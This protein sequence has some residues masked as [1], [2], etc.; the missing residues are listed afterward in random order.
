MGTEHSTESSMISSC[1]ICYNKYDRDT[2]IPCTLSCG[3]TFCIDCAKKSDKCSICK[4]NN[5]NKNDLKPTF[6]IMN[7]I[8]ES[9]SL[10]LKW[11]EV[12]KSLSPEYWDSVKIQQEKISELIQQA[13]M[14][15]E[16]MEEKMKK[17]KEMVEKCYS[18]YINSWEKN[19]DL[20]LRSKEEESKLIIG[21]DKEMKEFS[22]ND[23]ILKIMDNVKSQNEFQINLEK[24]KKDFESFKFRTFNVEYNT[25][26]YI[27]MK[28]PAFEDSF[29]QIEIVIPDDVNNESKMIPISG[30]F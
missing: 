25:Y 9:N 20:I 5:K 4:Q 15:Y 12:F 8:D 17:H 7:M 30:F 2:Y 13:N 14:R 6:E 21:L 29:V 3:H 26:R 24:L 28:P 27:T 18:D 16:K 23:H 19:Y 11:I 10:K 22:S 1:A